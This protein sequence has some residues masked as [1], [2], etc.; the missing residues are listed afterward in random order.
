[1]LVALFFRF[2]F[3]VDKAEHIMLYA[4]YLQQQLQQTCKLQT[5]S[6]F[7]AFYGTMK[8]Y[9]WCF[10]HN[11]DLHFVTLR[12]FLLAEKQLVLLG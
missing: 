12:L 3:R 4:T 5:D 2:V 7:C 9:V 1:M 8:Y 6:T 11:L 10:G